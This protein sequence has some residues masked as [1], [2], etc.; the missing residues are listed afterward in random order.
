MSSTK[1]LQT[2]PLLLLT[3]FAPLTA[4]ADAHGYATSAQG[5]QIRIYDVNL[6]TGTKV[7]IS[8]IQNIGI[9][10]LALSEDQAHLYGVAGEAF[11]TFDLTTG[12]LT[13]SINR[14]IADGIC[15]L[16]DM[17]KGLCK[18]GIKNFFAMTYDPSGRLI[19]V[20]TNTDG[21]QSLYVI[22]PTTGEP[23]ARLPIVI[24]S[25]VQPIYRLVQAITFFDSN[26]AL[27]TTG[28]GFGLEMINMQTGTMTQLATLPHPC[29]ALALGSDGQVHGLGSGGQLYRIDHIDLTANSAA[30]TQTGTTGV[31]LDSW[32]DLAAVPAPRIRQ[33]GTPDANGINGQALVPGGLGEIAGLGFAAANTVA[34]GDTLAQ[35]LAGVTVTIGG[36]TAPL[37]LVGGDRIRFQVPYEVTPGDST[38]TVTSPSGAM[39]AAV[40]VQAAL[41]SMVAI[42]NGV[43]LTP[44][45]DGG[46]AHNAATLGTLAA[47]FPWS[48]GSEIVVYI[49]GQGPLDSHPA[50]GYETSTNS[51]TVFPVS[52]FVDGTEAK[53]RSSVMSPGFVGVCEV[54]LEVPYSSTSA[55]AAADLS[56]LHTVQFSAGGFAGRAVTVNTR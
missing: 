12:V 6:T 3:A 31:P 42:S 22:D 55:Q 46:W 26:T 7:L 34:P 17:E 56:G 19:G 24:H 38:I 49:N 30:I 40:T 43:S 37:A 51:Q 29:W 54:H 14:Y 28:E 32:L 11:Y 5:G 41:P 47:G 39:S 27:V 23:V 44:S 33:V 50:D 48:A 4:Y 36:F 15:A 8:Q 20:S 25:L 18:P 1:L 10:A 21:T 52:A 2:L 53:V 9:S 35:N 16:A 13:H 45:R